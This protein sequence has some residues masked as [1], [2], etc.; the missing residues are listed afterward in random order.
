MKKTLQI[1]LKSNA[2]DKCNATMRNGTATK[3]SNNTVG[4]NG[5]SGS[6]SESEQFVNNNI[7]KASGVV[8][9]D[10]NL[11]YLKHVILKFL[12][13]REVSHSVSVFFFF[14]CNNK[15]VE[16]E[17]HLRRVLCCTCVVDKTDDFNV[18]FSYGIRSKRD[19]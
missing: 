15:C 1:E 10:V 9:D 3:P 13:S 12:T 16:D 7:G 5:N 19:I 14:W 2:N 6:G 11:K 17:L 8:M 18:Y 4:N